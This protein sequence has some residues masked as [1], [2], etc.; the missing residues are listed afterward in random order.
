MEMS[1]TKCLENNQYW[2]H[3]AFL[4]ASDQFDAGAGPC[5]VD[6]P[7]LHDQPEI[8]VDHQSR[9]RLLQARNRATRRQRGNALSLSKAGA[10]CP[11]VD[12]TPILAQ[13]CWQALNCGL[14]GNK[15]VVAKK[16][17]L[18][19]DT[20]ALQLLLNDDEN[21]LV[22]DIPTQALV[23]ALQIRTPP[24]QSPW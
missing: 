18:E 23:I 15:G 10:C 14:C 11:T 3:K 20:T 17:W 8:Q 21:N 1:M 6:T 4:S 22:L 13:A 16:R 7:K 24:R 19:I 5:K 9:L 2:R 12:A